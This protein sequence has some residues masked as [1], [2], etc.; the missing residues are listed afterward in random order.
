MAL[1]RLHRYGSAALLLALA[2]CTPA[3]P[4]AVPAASG[5]APSTQPQ[6]ADNQTLTFGL[7]ALS[8]DLDPHLTIGGTIRKWEMYETLILLDGKGTV[9]PLLA[10]QWEVVNPTTWRFTLRQDAKFHDGTPFT[11]EDVIYSFNRIN[12]PE[13]KSPVKGTV[14]SLDQMMAID[15]YTVEMTTKIPDPLFGKRMWYIGMVSKAYVERVGDAAMLTQPMG[16]GPYKNEGVQG[17]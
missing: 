8:T 2:A 13:L 5:P 6:R 14:V 3:A 9:K 10:T 4:Q 17:R 7:P 11:S 15:K 1:S 16:T 12:K